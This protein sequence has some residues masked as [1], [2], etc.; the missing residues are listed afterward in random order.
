MVL[1]DGDNSAKSK[2]LPYEFYRLCHSVQLPV[3]VRERVMV[4]FAHNE[5]AF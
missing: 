3:S 5:Y 4:R 2:E 1:V